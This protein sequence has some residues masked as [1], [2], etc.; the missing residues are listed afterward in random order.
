MKQIIA[1]LILLLLSSCAMRNE[2]RSERFL[3]LQGEKLETDPE[4]SLFEIVYANDS[5]IVAT[6]ISP[7][8]QLA[9]IPIGGR[10]ETRQFLHKGRGPM[11]VVY[12]KVKSYNDSLFVLSHDPYGINGLIKIPVSGI[13][14]MTE[15]EYIDFS[16]IDNLGIGNDFDLLTSSDYIVLGGEYGR[17]S[18]LARLSERNLTWSSVPFWPD[19]GYK[20]EA[21]PKQML[22]TRNSK[23]FSNGDKIFYA[24]GEGRYF[25]ILN[26]SEDPVSESFIYDEYPS[27]S[28]GPDG[29]NPK[30]A[31]ESK[32]GGIACATDSAIYI[33]L[34]N[35]LLSPAG[36]YV[37]D[38]YKGYPP[39]YIDVIE[40]YGWNGEYLCTYTLDTPFATFFVSGRY[41]YTVTVNRDTMLSEI[42]RYDLPQEAWPID[43]IDG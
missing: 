41:L 23:V 40:V 20:G 10:S 42:Y 2:D 31:P 6:L 9:A 5:L 30:R 35:C 36:Y 37:P 16:D 39:Y 21:L 19:D 28:V 1:T 25:S 8:C 34:L 12:A 15:W 26:I 24:S 18:I 17:E 38:N 7:D 43:H 11:E 4:M 32:L 29:L 3:S 14:D 13:Q 22:Y 33:G 27:Y